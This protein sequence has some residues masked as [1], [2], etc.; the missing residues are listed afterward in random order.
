MAFTL[1]C[2]A[3]IPYLNELIHSVSEKTFSGDVSRNAKTTTSPVKLIRYSGDEELDEFLPFAD[4]LLIRTVTRI[5]RSRFDD[6]PD[7]LK[8]VA[9]ATA[10]IDH[11]DTEFLSQQ[12][13][14]FFHSPGCNARAV[15]EYVISMFFR[16]TEGELSRIREAGAG[17]I[18][19][20]NTGTHLAKILNQLEIP[21]LTTDPPK[22]HATNGRWQ[23]VKFGDVL[24]QGFLSFHVPLTRSHESD[25]PTFGMFGM[26]EFRPEKQQCIVHACRGG[27]LNEEDLVNIKS[28][29]NA[30]FLAVDVWKNEPTP[31]HRELI[32]KADISTPHIAGYSRQAKLQASLIALNQI[33]RFFG[34]PEAAESA[35]PEVSEIQEI[36]ASRGLTEIINQHPAFEL[37]QL[38]KDDPQQFAK[39]RN[40]WPLR[41]QYSHSRLRNLPPEN[42]Q[43]QTAKALGFI[44]LQ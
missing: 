39:L 11:V 42:N 14:A 16:A 30:P 31:L 41:Q 17:I 29:A 34:L 12:N 18:G 8:V 6:F 27:V 19:M 22:E 9:S 35:V 33:L 5:T 21:F 25:W 28:G 2:D 13:I 15:A 32:K 20:G 23:G 1:L 44:L 37:S 40:T 24:N 3:H 10:G 7:R 26:R 4:A 43:H 36:D 38:L